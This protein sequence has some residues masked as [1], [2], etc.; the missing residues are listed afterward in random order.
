MES[1]KV[2]QRPLPAIPLI[3]GAFFTLAGVL[4]TLDNFDLV[5]ASRVLRFW[6]LALVGAGLAKLLDPALVSG[7]DGVRRGAGGQ[8]GA[9]ALIVIG[10]LFVADNLGYIRFELFDLWPLILIGVGA[11]FVARSM[12][13]RPPRAMN[14]RSGGTDLA[15][16]GEQ[17]VRVDTRDYRGGSA[18]AFLG[19]LKVDLTDADIAHG[20]AVLYTRAMWGSVEIIV[21]E[22]W[23][24]I[25]DVTPFMAAFEMKTQGPSDPSRTL[26]VRG[27]AMWAGIEVKRAERRN[28]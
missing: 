14:E 8:V 25:G 15:L 11:M 16:L 18:S 28:A 13:A 27:G 24:V 6:P 5:D 26:I 12:E 19:S 21:P 17:S 7:A 2:E 20:P 23:E 1:S 22:R 3:A 4:L 10:T 9:I